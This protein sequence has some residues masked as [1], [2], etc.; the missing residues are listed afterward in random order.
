MKGRACSRS[1]ISGELPLAAGKLTPEL[2]W[3]DCG[4]RRISTR[5]LGARRAQARRPVTDEQRRPRVDSQA[6]RGQPKRVP[7][8]IMGW[9]DH[10]D[11]RVLASVQGGL[12]LEASLS[13]ARMAALACAFVAAIP[14]I[15]C[16]PGRGAPEGPAPKSQRPPAVDSR[17]AGAR[18][19][20][21]AV[22]LVDTSLSLDP[23]CRLAVDGGQRKATIAL[24][25]VPPCAWVGNVGNPQ[26]VKT[27]A[28]PMILAISS[29]PRPGSARD[30]DTHVRAIS[31]KGSVLL[32]SK[33]E[34]RIASCSREEMDEVM[35][36]SFA[37]GMEEMM[38]WSERN[39]DG[40][41]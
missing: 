19:S 6:R 30:C 28:G 15:A 14:A 18:S 3:V 5:G 10:E 9:L 32:M 23:A 25:L 24:P 12:A 13:P 41:K 11:R 7:G 20:S 17:P 31:V 8:L 27:K 40:G 37:A 21:V 33:A 29:R 4:S 38:S 39:R 22:R 35:F 26:V 2:A 16:S 1:R 34:Q 36:H